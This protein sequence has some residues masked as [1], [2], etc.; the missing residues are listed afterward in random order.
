MLALWMPAAPAHKSA[1]YRASPRAVAAM[2]EKPPP[3]NPRSPKAEASVG[4]RGDVPRAAMVSALRK[5][6][7]GMG[8]LHWNVSMHNGRDVSRGSSVLFQN[9]SK[10]NPK[11]F[12]KQQIWLRDGRKL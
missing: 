6:V 10:M 3:P 2:L 11:R 9:G 5:D 7:C 4:R 8:D 12:R 1:Q